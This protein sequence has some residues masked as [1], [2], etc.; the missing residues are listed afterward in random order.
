MVIVGVA[1]CVVVP[2]ETVVLVI[3]AGPLPPN[4]IEVVGFPFGP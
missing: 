1:I 4:K 2:E 3:T